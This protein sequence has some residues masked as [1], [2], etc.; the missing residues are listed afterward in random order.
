[1][2]A[3][4][5]AHCAPGIAADWLDGWAEAKGEHMHLRA[6]AAGHRRGFLQVDRTAVL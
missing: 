4:A 2:P 6:S 5:I 3:Y 1:M